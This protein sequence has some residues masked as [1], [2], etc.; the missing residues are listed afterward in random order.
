MNI[1]NEMAKG[2]GIPA[3]TRPFRYHKAAYCSTIQLPRVIEEAPA[4]KGASY[5]RNMIVGLEDRIKLMMPGGSI[6]A[7]ITR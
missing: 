3:A 1:I 2:Y 7:G 4:V 5:L 6:R